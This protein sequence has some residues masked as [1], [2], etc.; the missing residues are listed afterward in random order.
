MPEKS[1]PSLAISSWSLHRALGL[2]FPN[3][4]DN[5]IVPDAEPTYGFGEITLL[6]LPETVA[7]L[8]VDRVEI[9]SFHIPTRHAGYLA[10]VRSA[11][12]AS[13]V[14][15][16][17]LLIEYGDITN[18]E[19]A[20]RDLAWIESWI[21]AA[22]L[23]GAEQ[24]RVIAGKAQ[25]SRE[26]LDRSAAGLRRLGRYGASRGVSI[27]TENWFDLLATPEH[28]D[29]LFDRLEGTVALNGDFGNWSGATKYA[30]LEAIFGR[31]VCCHAKADFR[32]GELDAADYRRCLEAAEAAGF[33]GPYTLIYDGPD[34][35][36]RAHLAI[37]RDFIRAYFS[38]GRQAA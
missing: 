1:A 2:T 36:E 5:N 38:E 37:E 13:H 12:A 18:P 7:A 35:D 11:L 31:A 34:A 16:Q 17:T 20:E 21:D 15:L 24:A 19:T 22:A 6:D 10:E 8:D 23:L 26:A 3:R 27:V 30:D 29:Y 25:P 14:R 33:G 9:C 28:V 32:S 4:P